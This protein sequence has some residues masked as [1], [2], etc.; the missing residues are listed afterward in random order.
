M[1][2]KASKPDLRVVVDNSAEM[3]G[4]DAAAL[5]RHPVPGG[6]KYRSRS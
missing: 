4:A 1:I 5:E 2:K 3:D 6:W